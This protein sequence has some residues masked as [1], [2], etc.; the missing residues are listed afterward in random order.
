MTKDEIISS[1]HA[2][3]QA[4]RDAHRFAA[5]DR[6]GDASDRLTEANRIADKRREYI[7]AN[8]DQGGGAGGGFQ[9]VSYADHVPNGEAR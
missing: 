7:R 8:P 5:E 1:L 2:E 4:L 9:F 3:N 6:L